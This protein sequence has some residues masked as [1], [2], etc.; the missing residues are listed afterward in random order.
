MKKTFPLLLVFLLLLTGCAQKAGS[1]SEDDLVKAQQ[2]T[3]ASADGSLLR[4]ITDREEIQAL[5]EALY[6]ESWTPASVPQDAR[7]VGTLTFL[8]EDTLHFGETS[9]DGKLHPVSELTVYEDGFFCLDAAGM[10]LAFAV[11]D[12]DA[13]ELAG[14]FDA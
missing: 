11:S 1:S 12:A 4:T 9:T 13:A 14:L 6:P 8:Q 3:V 5:V 2:I 10:E 7:V